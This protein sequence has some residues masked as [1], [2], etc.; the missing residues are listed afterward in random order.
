MAL[1]EASA[2][3]S[4]AVSAQGSFYTILQY[5]CDI[6]RQCEHFREGVPCMCCSDGMSLFKGIPILTAGQTGFAPAALSAV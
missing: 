6:L 5:F 1:K 4:K 2:A 3:A